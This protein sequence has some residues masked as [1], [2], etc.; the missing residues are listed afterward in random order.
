M[1]YSVDSLENLMTALGGRG[2]FQLMAHVLIASSYISLVFHHVIMAF[3][4]S[5][6]PH[7]CMANVGNS[8]AIFEGNLTNDVTNTSHSQCSTTFY[9]SDGRNETVLCTAGQWMYTPVHNE[10]NIV[11]QFDLVCSDAYLVNLATTVYF[12]GVT[13]G[14]LVFGDLADRYG[15]LPVMLFT[16]YTSS[17]LGVI[18]AFSV[19]YTM[20]VVLRFIQG[21]LL[22]GL[23]TSAYTL[24]IELYVAKHRP[25]AGV[26]TECFFGS[27]VIVLAGLAYLLRNWRHLQ[28]GISVVGVT[29]LAH[30]WIVPESIR[31]LIMKRK[32]KK[33][34]SVIKRVC[35][36]N[37]I[38]V[39]DKE[40]E[41]IKRET[42]KST[43]GPIRQCNLTDLIRNGQMRQRSLILFYI[44]LVISTCYYGL[45]FKLSSLHGNPYLLFCIG[46]V[47]ETSAYALSLPMMKIFGRKKPLLATL[48]I[49]AVTCIAAGFMNDYL[50]GY[51]YLIAALAVAGRCAASCQFAIIFVYTSEIYPT[52]MRNIGMGA[53]CFWA[54]V[55]GIV[56]PQINHWTKALWNV[57]AIII[58]GV[59]SFIAALTLFPLPETHNQNLPDTIQE[60]ETKNTEQDHEAFE[61]NLVSDKIC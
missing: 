13:I 37:K 16:L 53:C 35:K 18:I 21:M 15:R 8:S 27:S 43:A 23:Q 48:I 56:A 26:V 22:Q 41:I 14:G 2:K 57:D 50:S 39:P 24:V 31:W 7:T 42:N 46:G 19:N 25:F 40:W 33:A 4:G 60:T 36:F 17:V 55:G 38:P 28:I 30:P 12:S 61:F 47:F 32:T 5:P 34:F 3:H 6:V 59:C 54:R 52:V 1:T 45:T 11:S 51:S 58:F 49:A 29:A 44:W 20:F 10:W 9:F